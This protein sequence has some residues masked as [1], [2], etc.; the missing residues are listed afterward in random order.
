MFACICSNFRCLRRVEKRVINQ[1]WEGS[2]SAALQQ[3][4]SVVVAELENLVVDNINNWIFCPVHIYAGKCGS[5]TA[6]VRG[7]ENASASLREHTALFKQG[8]S[9]C[10]LLYVYINFRHLA[11]GSL[12]L[13]S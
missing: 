3:L 4:V 6:L 5:R 8:L 12:K 1:F 9:H 13:M 10:I 11:A 7:M 2:A